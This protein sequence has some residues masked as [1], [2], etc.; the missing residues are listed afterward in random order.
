MVAREFER[1]FQMVVRE[2]EPRSCPFAVDE[3]HCI[4]SVSEA[5]VYAAP[6]EAHSYPL[7]KTINASHYT[8]LVG[9]DNERFFYYYYFIYNSRKQTTMKAHLLLIKK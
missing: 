6:V 9:S 8:C 4:T 5:I 3:I 2:Y 1:N 7:R